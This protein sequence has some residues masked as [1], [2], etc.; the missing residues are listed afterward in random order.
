M[1]SSPFKPKKLDGYQP[2]YCKQGNS[3]K[4]GCVFYKKDG[5]NYKLRKDLDIA[6]IM[7]NVINFSVVGL[8]L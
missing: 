1:D 2:Y 7:M 3:L 6:Y 8:R 4:S 5:I